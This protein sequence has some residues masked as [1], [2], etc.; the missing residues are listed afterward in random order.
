MIISNGGCIGGYD[1][2]SGDYNIWYQNPRVW[3]PNEPGQCC[4]VSGEGGIYAEN[5]YAVQVSCYD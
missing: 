5:S 4:A 2:R 1:I 3:S